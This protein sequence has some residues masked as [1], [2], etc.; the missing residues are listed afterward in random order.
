MSNS[1]AKRLNAF[2]T[3]QCTETGIERVVALCSFLSAF[4]KL[5]I[6]T[7]TFVMSVSPSVRTEQLLSHWT[8]SHEI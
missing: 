4:A 7:I 8:D 1:G 6:A 2:V 3:V 5:Q